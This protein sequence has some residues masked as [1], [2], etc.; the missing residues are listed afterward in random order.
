MAVK[1]VVGRKRLFTLNQRISCIAPQSKSSTPSKSAAE[2]DL[3][4]H[5]CR[6]YFMPQINIDIQKH[7]VA[8]HN[9]QLA[10]ITSPTI[11]PIVYF[12]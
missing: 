5:F 3:Q 1:P 9:A 6:R 8:A 12:R 7:P 10:D 11:T 4:P 2:P